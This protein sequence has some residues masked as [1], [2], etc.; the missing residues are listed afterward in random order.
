MRGC[1]P[2]PE[3]PAGGSL[4]FLV[5]VVTATTLPAR[6]K[7]KLRPAGVLRTSYLCFRPVLGADGVMQPPKRERNCTR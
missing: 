1:T 3:A 5:D 6:S 4:G 2:L 7:R